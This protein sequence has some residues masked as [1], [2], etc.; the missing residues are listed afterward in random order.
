MKKNHN[1]II[2][3][4]SQAQ[5]AIPLSILVILLK[6]LQ[7]DSRKVYQEKIEIIADYIKFSIKDEANRKNAFNA[8]KNFT[9]KKIQE[10]PR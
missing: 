8:L 5:D 3:E 7:A 10:K 1:D 6:Q 9:K 4:L 2:A